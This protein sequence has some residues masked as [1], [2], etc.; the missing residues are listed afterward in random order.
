MVRRNDHA[1]RKS[2]LSARG[3]RHW[4]DRDR[5]NSA[6]CAAR[7]RPR[8]GAGD[9]GLRQQA[10]R[11]ARRPA[12][13][14][15]RRRAASRT[16]WSMS[17]TACSSKPTRPSSTPQSRATLDKQAQWLTNYGQYTFTIEGHADER[18]TREYNIALGARRAQ[19]VAR[20][21]DLAR[22]PGQ[23]H[24]HHLLRQGAAGRGLQRHLVLVA[25]PPRGDGAQRQFV[26]A[27]SLRSITACPAC[28]GHRRFGR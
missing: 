27:R 14:R 17:A 9:F 22:H 15:R 4:N 8:R 3:W 19:T 6:R 25:E 1:A 2:L 20:L 21:S 12:P 24:A 28:A 13:A 10:G 16:S 26:S 11:Q 23:P 18:G 5:A 7:G